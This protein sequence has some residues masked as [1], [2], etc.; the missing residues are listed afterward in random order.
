MSK[1]TKQSMECLR[2]LLACIDQC[3]VLK[4]ENHQ[5]LSRYNPEDYTLETY[6]DSDW[7]KQRTP[8]RSVSAGYLFMFGNLLYSSSGSQKAL[9]LS[10]CEA[11]VYAGASASDA[12]LMPHCICFC[13]GPDEIV[14]MKLAL[15]DS[16]GRSFF[17]HAG[18]GRIRHISLRVLWMQEQ[19]RDG[20]LSAGQSNHVCY[21]AWRL[22]PYAV[23]ASPPRFAA[24]EATDGDNYV[25]M[26]PAF[27]MTLLC[28]AFG[29]IAVL[30]FQLKELQGEK[31][32]NRRNDALMK[33]VDFLKRVSLRTKGLVHATQKMLRK[34]V[35]KKSP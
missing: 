33:A 11:E 25:P 20:L 14:K 23:A 9:A 17:H 4:Y 31:S 18:V 21:V 35:Q 19:V 6:S 7:A 27:L 15:D 3:I 26:A 10:S 28:I 2:Y 8:R 16:A 13:G 22:E 34:K 5:G 30:L 24:S 1:L 32:Q 12:I 29:C